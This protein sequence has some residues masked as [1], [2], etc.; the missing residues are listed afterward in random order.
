[1]RLH[2]QHEQE[3]LRRVQHFLDTHADVVGPLKDSEARKQL[4]DAV[5]KLNAHTLD[6]GTARLEASGQ[7][8]R[9]Q[10]AA[11][12]LKSEHMQPIAKFARAKLKGV[13]DV[14]ALTKSG[15][16]LHGNK[17]VSA[18]RAMATAALPHADVLTKG[19]FPADAVQQLGTAADALSA[20]ITD[21]AATKVQGVVAT[22]GIRKETLRG[23]EAVHMLDAVV[24]KPLAS[25]PELQAG[26]RS[27]KR[28]TLK[29]GGSGTPAAVS[30]PVAP[31]PKEVK[32]QTAAA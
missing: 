13:P 20:A 2:Q 18:A 24:S 11:N 30:A 10:Q 31:L 1:M 25:N 8:H 32:P 7:T 27:A 21:R 4:D 22:A 9:Q 23:R 5:A 6:Q 17:L 26:W 3:A 14:A 12:V 29:S 16:N 19:G 28:V 15:A